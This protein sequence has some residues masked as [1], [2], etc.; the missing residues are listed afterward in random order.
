MSAR[1]L[2]DSTGIAY[3]TVQGILTGT[4]EPKLT[5][6]YLLADALNIEVADL[7]DAHIKAHTG[8]I[9]R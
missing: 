6:L 5:H 7:I 2:S 3:P 8:E 9:V 4:R 1:Q